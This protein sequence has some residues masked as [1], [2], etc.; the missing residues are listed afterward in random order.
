[1]IQTTTLPNGLRII[2]LLS[3][4]LVSYCGFAVNA[5]T[6]DELAGQFGLAHF[7]EHTLFKGT[8]KRKAWHILNRMEAVGG[9]LN[10]YTTKEETFLYS[11]CLSEDIERA[12]ELLGDLIFKSVFPEPEI[13]K[14]RE[15][16][17]DEIHSYEDNPSELI[18]DEFENLIFRNHAIGHSILGTED[19]VNS[20]TSDSCRQFV[21][22][23]YSPANMIF[24]FY[25]KTSF[26]KIQSLAE[27]YF[28]CPSAKADG[29][30]MDGGDG[31]KNRIVPLPLLPMQEK[32]D[33]NLH[34]SHVILGNRAYSLHNRQRM[35]LYLLNNLL[36]GPGMNSRLNVS[37]RE[38][39]GLV[40]SVESGM[41]AYS[42]T[43]LFHIY[44]GCDSDSVE[45]CLRLI[46][47]EL[48]Q[49]Q[50]TGLSATQLHAAQKQL[51]GQLGVASDHR[52]NIAL[53][54]GKSF[55]HFNK[56][57][58]LPEVYRKIDALTSKQLLE[59]ANEIF[60]EKQLF[61]LIFE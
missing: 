3:D 7:V 9:E 4:S 17:I 26:L 41:T 60:D 20:F 10:A 8:R 12:M 24:F 6:R 45:K 33:K 25:G 1:M 14:E 15:V 31:V 39:N 32:I 54:M 35:G 48:R 19:S 21:A 34:Q 37:L 42:D 61:Q 58:L 28:L 47:K 51:K 18:F 59:I 57:E 53:G 27:K 13:E 16:V 23:F 49:L 40:Y 50:E 38:K 11:I 55:L 44:F 5:G 2:T 43:G 29:N 36:G 56:Y 22:D 30:E 52:E 46:H